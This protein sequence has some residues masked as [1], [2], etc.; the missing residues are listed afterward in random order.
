M[1]HPCE[2]PEEES[3][4]RN[5]LVRFPALLPST[6]AARNVWLFKAIGIK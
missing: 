6:I 3:K 5:R 1:R 2:N 4:R